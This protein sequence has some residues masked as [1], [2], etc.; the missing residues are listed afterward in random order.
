MCVLVF[1]LCCVVGAGVCGLVGFFLFWPYLEQSCGTCIFVMFV[2][3][4]LP[5]LLAGSGTDS[6]GSL[7]QGV[8]ATVFC[9]H[10]VIA[11]P[12]QVLI[13]VSG[14]PLHCCCGASFRF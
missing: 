3:G 2:W 12:L 8:D 5:L 6:S 9:S 10:V 11:I 7:C 4:V 14:L 1:T 13:C